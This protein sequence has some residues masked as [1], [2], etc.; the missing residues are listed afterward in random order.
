MRFKAKVLT[1]VREDEERDFV[2]SFF[3]DNDEI[4]LYI[5]IYIY[6]YIY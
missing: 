1:P 3:L 4:R 6:I 2:I 5:Y